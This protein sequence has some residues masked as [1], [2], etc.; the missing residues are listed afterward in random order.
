MCIRDR[1][2]GGLGRLAAG[3][4]DSMAAGGIAGD[5]NGMRYR[6]G[7]FHQDIEG[8]RQVERTDNWLANGFPWDLRCGQRRD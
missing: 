2:N 8:G 1:G 5:G 4:L 7:L 3:F 6:Y